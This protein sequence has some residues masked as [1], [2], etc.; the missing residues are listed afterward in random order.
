M[1]SQNKAVEIVKS[2]LGSLIEYELHVK[3]GAEHRYAIYGNYDWENL[4]VVHVLE[5]NLSNTTL[6]STFIVLIHKE[7]GDVVYKGYANDEG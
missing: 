6:Q 5:S 2:R 7:S 3:D 4:W 1:I